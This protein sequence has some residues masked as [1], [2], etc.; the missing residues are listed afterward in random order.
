MGQWVD[1]GGLAARSLVVSRFW[2]DGG[3]MFG[4]V[5]KVLWNRYT[6]ADQQNRIPLV[7]RAL[8]VRSG[9]RLAL[10]EPGMGGDYPP[11]EIEQ[12]RIDP[13]LAD[14]GVV[15]RGA[16]IDP[17]EVTDVIVT[18]LHFDHVGGIS[19]RDA[20]GSVKA[21]MPAA[22]V[23]VQK[24]QW[25]RAQAP[26]PKERRS[27][28]SQDLEFLRGSNLVLLQGAAEPLPGVVVRSSE[29][30]T[31]GQQWVIARGAR[32]TIYYPTDLI[33]TLAHIRAAYTMGFD[34]RPESVITEKEALLAEAAEDDGIVVFVHDPR[35]GA[36]RV[37]KGSAGFAVRNREPEWE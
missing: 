22:R 13:A 23:F 31:L 25:E 2:L 20:D 4:Q 5:P 17:L 6:T 28:R 15:L 27:F 7:V 8:L 21:V 35:T 37:M 3:S 9:D 32:K 14:L 1:L 30:H 19:R 11:D 16:G 10:V 33:P 34:L 18:H 12:L 29:G 26:G 24:D 36:C